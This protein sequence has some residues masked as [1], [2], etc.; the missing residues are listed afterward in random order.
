[1]QHYYDLLQQKAQLFGEQ[2]Q[3]SLLHEECDDEVLLLYSKQQSFRKEIEDKLNS[4]FRSK[5]SA[6]MILIGNQYESK[7]FILASLQSIIKD[8]LISESAE[9]SIQDVRKQL[10]FIDGAAATSDQDAFTLLSDQ[11]LGV[12]QPLLNNMERNITTILLDLENY[13]HQ[14]RINNVPAIILVDSFHCFANYK[15]QTFIYTLLDFVHKS[16]LFFLV[17]TFPQFYILI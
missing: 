5:Q 6:S 4:S 13:F 11:L 2:K 16:E 17:V 14:C 12:N 10:F 8:F 9:I 15:R 3:D 1:M 7:K